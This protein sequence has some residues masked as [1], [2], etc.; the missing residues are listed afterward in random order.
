[1]KLLAFTDLHG[2]NKALRQIKDKAKKQKPDLIVCAGDISI[3]GDKFMHLVSEI[4]QLGILF[5]IVPGN[6]ESDSLIH[7]AERM[8]DNVKDLHRKQIELGGYIFFGFGGGGFSL[9][10][11]EFEKLSK[12]LK[13]SAKPAK[14]LILVTHAPPYNTKV[15]EIHGE[16][17]GNKSIR[18]FIVSAKPVLA[19]C[20]HLHEN[21][22][23]EDKI[24]ITRIINPGYSGKI[25][26]I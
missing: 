18:Q 16:H 4:S 9:V 7:R 26:T 21:E 12:E 17:A 25:L 22:G 2:D 5:L 1:M 13:F 11:R 10:D 8:F 6:H 14:K 23:K 3:F 20:G 15:D 19:I 24:G